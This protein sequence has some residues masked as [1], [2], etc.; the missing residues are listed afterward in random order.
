MIAIGGT[1]R[2][3][4]GLGLGLGDGWSDVRRLIGRRCCSWFRSRRHR[5]FQRYDCIPSDRL[6]DLCHDL[7]T[8]IASAAIVHENLRHFTGQAGRARGFQPPR[9]N[10]ILSPVA[11]MPRLAKIDSCPLKRS[12]SYLILTVALRD[13]PPAPTRRTPRR[14][15][16][17]RID[18]AARRDNGRPFRVAVPS[19]LPIPVCVGARPVQL[20]DERSS[21]IKLSKIPR[22]GARP[23]GRSVPVRDYNPSDRD[24]SIWRKYKSP[25]R[26]AWGTP[27][28]CK[29]TS[30]AHAHK[31]PR[32]GKPSCKFLATLG[33]RL[34]HRVNAPGE[35]RFRPRQMSVLS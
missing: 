16:K 4:Y 15:A 27:G 23:P 14:I 32:C 33:T 9:A 26:R 13:R 12:F 22:R 3:H 6:P 20:L 2:L 18:K 24:R 25:A 1:I 10:T 19:K 35:R 34:P 31:R 29:A 17:R 21:A 8:R 7:P 11:Q 28:L 30:S 5:L